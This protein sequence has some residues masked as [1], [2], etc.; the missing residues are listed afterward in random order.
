M[1]E[2]INLDEIPQM[3]EN[4]SLT[5]KDA[6][7]RVLGA[8]YT[9]PC[10][11][12]LHDMDEEERSD[13]LLDSLERFQR[14]LCRYD[15]KQ[16]PLGAFI[17][18][19][20]PGIRKTWTKRRKEED[21]SKKAVRR[22]LKNIYKDDLEDNEISWEIKESDGLKVKDSAGENLEE[23]LL[24]KRVFGRRS[25][26]LETKDF[27]YKR[28]AA[29]ILALKSAWYID[30]E[31]VGKLS[32]YCGFSK[33]CVFKAIRKV[34]KGLE[35]RQKQRAELELRRDKAWL[36]VCK[37]RE[38]LANADPESERYKTLK[39]KLDYQLN[40]WKNK[41]KILQSC[42]MTLAPKNKDLAK[43]FKIEPYKV[44]VLLKYAKQMAASGETLF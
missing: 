7:M 4:G 26:L 22:N 23:P 44:S 41:T 40:S 13:F 24:F 17:F 29:F 43:M 34:R 9:N 3:L 27:F 35:P 11:F 32:G 30:D 21:M 20:L 42:Q 8:L 28:R 12:N 14:L 18:Y 6:V 5:I 39:R 33:E 1:V 2:Q 16:G 25:S 36:F 38:M 15:K 31:S 37:Y 10:R 19:S